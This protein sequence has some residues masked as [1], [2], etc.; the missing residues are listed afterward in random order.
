MG[1]KLSIAF[2]SLNFC[3]ASSALEEFMGRECTTT[4]L[5]CEAPSLRVQAMINWLVIFIT[6]SAAPVGR[7]LYSSFWLVTATSYAA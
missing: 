1:I 7:W 5:S 3:H 2:P 4:R 6:D